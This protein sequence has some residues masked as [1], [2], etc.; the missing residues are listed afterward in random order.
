MTKSARVKP[1]HG[2]WLIAGK[3]PPAWSTSIIICREFMMDI[4][5]RIR[6]MGEPRMRGSP[7]KDFLS[8]PHRNGFIHAHKK[9]RK[10]AE[11]IKSP[12]DSCG[13]QSGKKKSNTTATVSPRKTSSETRRRPFEA[14]PPPP[15][16]P[17]WE[18]S[19]DD[20]TSPEGM[21]SGVLSSTTCPSSSLLTGSYI[22][23]RFSLAS[24]IN[25]RQ[26]NVHT[27]LFPTSTNSLPLNRH[28]LLLL[29][30]LLRSLS[31][32]RYMCMLGVLVGGGIRVSHINFISY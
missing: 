32:V 17:R 20:S 29:L 2:E 28:Q 13:N 5:E 15:P 21:L 31:A 30:L 27:P 24:S 19:R 6:Q 7:D 22:P 9:Q 16:S 12:E 8:S 26:S 25:V 11:K 10:V 14:L 3:T 1:F 18:F 23:T 4:I